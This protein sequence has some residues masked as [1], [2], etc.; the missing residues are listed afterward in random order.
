MKISKEILLEK[1]YEGTRLI[2][3]KDPKIKQLHKELSKL[4]VEANPHLKIMESITPK[5]DPLF[6]KLREL[7]LEKEKVKAQMAPIRAPYDKEL[8]EVEK[9]DQRAQLIKNKIQPLVLKTIQPLLSEFE[10]A[11]QLIEK[12]GSMFVE[13]TDEIEEKIKAIRASKLKK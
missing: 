1:N 11:N 13:V 6:T 7:E 4:Q 9:I 12:N 2:E 8:K 5:M 10:K 3:I